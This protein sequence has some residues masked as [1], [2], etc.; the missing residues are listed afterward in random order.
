M[1]NKRMAFHVLIKYVFI[2]HINVKN[3]EKAAQTQQ[4]VDEIAL[5]ISIQFASWFLL[6]L[7]EK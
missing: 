6:S 1:T 2:A 5:E 4:S 7:G 3:G